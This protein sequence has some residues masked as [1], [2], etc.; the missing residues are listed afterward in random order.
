MSLEFVLLVSLAIQHRLYF[1]H[2]ASGVASACFRV[3]LRL[4]EGS[5]AVGGLDFEMISRLV[6]SIEARKIVEDV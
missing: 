1:A 4:G 6:C 5:P 2:D 3:G